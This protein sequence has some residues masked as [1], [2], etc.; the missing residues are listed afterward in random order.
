MIFRRPGN[1]SG[2]LGLTDGPV[3]V[4]VPDPGGRYYL[5]PTLSLCTD[6]IGSPGW[7]TTGTGP[8]DF[9][10][11]PPEWTGDLPEGIPG[12]ERGRSGLHR[13]LDGPRLR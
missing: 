13:R 4:S 12:P 1:S 7:R 8:H 11:I 2:W 6:V 3:V 9:V 5:L 10:Y